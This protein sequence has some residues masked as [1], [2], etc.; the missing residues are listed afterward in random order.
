YRLGPAWKAVIEVA[1]RD[2]VLPEVDA[3]SGELQL[4]ASRMSLLEAIVPRFDGSRIT[5][6]LQKPAPWCFRYVSEVRLLR[7]VWRWRG[8]PVPPFPADAAAPGLIDA[9][10]PDAAG[11]DLTQSELDAPDLPQLWDAIGFGDRSTTDLLDQSTGIAAANASATLYTENLAGDRRAL[12]FR[13][14]AQATGRYAALFPGERLECQASEIAKWHDPKKQEV[15][16]ANAWRR[17]FVPARREEELPK[18]AVRFVVP[19]TESEADSR[20]ATTPGLLVVL[21]DTW[22]SYGGLAEVLEAEISMASDYY[23]DNTASEPVA[24]RPEFGPD[25]TLTNRGW[26][27]VDVGEAAEG[28]PD[29]LHAPSEALSMQI[30]GPIG[31]TF[32]T[33]AEAPLYNAT[34]FILR[35]PGVDAVDGQGTAAGE[36]DPW[37]GDSLAWYFAKIRFRRVLLPEAT[38]DYRTGLQITISAEQPFSFVLAKDRGWVV[39]LPRILITRD[40]GT[41]VDFKIKLESSSLFGVVRILQSGDKLDLLS[42]PTDANL[43]NKA[44][45][46]EAANW[47]EVELDLR[48][49]HVLDTKTEPEVPGDTSRKPQPRH[50]SVQYRIRAVRNEPTTS[51]TGER[52]EPVSPGRVWHLLER[53]NWASDDDHAWPEHWKLSATG[54]VQCATPQALPARTS[55]YTDPQWVQFLPDSLLLRR[56]VTDD[57]AKAGRPAHF[58]LRWLPIPGGAV[59]DPLQAQLLRRFGDDGEWTHVTKHLSVREQ[60]TFGDVT[61][62]RFAL[63]TEMVSDVRGQLGQER[64]LGLFKFTDDTN[65]D[66]CSLDVTHRF[67]DVR[68]EEIRKSRRLRVRIIEFQFVHADEAVSDDSLKFGPWSHLFAEQP[69]PQTKDAAARVVSVSPPIELQRYN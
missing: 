28:D 9:F 64:Y 45:L 20:R 58:S 60:A 8:R 27:K 69:E 34:S 46:I 30:V 42:G 50:T 26:T 22:F 51:P 10:P 47:H 43:P 23:R 1:T 36:S 11:R 39:D 56:L 57:D 16:V 21:D 2:V 18:P 63:L 3:S 40:T 53:R 38:A 44:L 7:Q 52:M 17:L 25:P 67:P 32:D 41:D 5:V 33:G 6:H 37:Y 65:P 19:L 54:N 61:F 29:E 31:H 55:S 66:N 24:F 13:F 62:R 48:V 59:E 35:P 4:A 14:G 12:Y 49:M 15:N 68:P